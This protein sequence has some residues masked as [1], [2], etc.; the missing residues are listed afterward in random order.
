L[1]GLLHDLLQD[2]PLFLILSR[3]YRLASTVEIKIKKIMSADESK[4]LW[5]IDEKPSRSFSL[6]ITML[7]IEYFIIEININTLYFTV[8]FYN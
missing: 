2:Y 5:F 6:F 3:T 8:Y 1:W 4:K 7:I